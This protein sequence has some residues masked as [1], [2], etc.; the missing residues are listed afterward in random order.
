VRWKPYDEMSRLEQKMFWA[1]REETMLHEL[2]MPEVD[3]PG[4][5]HEVRWPAERPA[6]CAAVLLRWFDDGLI[7]VRLTDSQT[8]LPRIEAREVLADHSAWSTIHSLVITE[9][10]EAALT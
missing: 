8:H 1:V 4:G 5:A 9:A 6:D 7:G 2:P 3:D 10:G